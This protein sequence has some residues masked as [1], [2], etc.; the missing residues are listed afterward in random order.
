MAYT[1]TNYRDVEPV[2]DAMYFLRDPLACERLG[3][4][5]IECDQGW[6]GKEHDHA[7]DD[8]KEVYLL[9]DGT[10]TITVDGDEVALE[11]GNALRVAPDATRQ[12]QNGDTEST[13]VIAGAP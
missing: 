3:V 1:A 5:V 9:L 11:P 7:A 2:A 13:F 4:T 12:I 6:T 10:A 8:H